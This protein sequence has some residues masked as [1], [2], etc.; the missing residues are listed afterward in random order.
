MKGKTINLLL[1]FF[2][3]LDNFCYKKISKL[4]IL[5]NNGIH[6]KHRI[7]NYHQFFV[8]NIEKGDR[9]LDVGCG[10]GAV[11]YDLA[12]KAKSV[13]GIDINKQNVE[14]AKK[15]YRHKNLNFIVGDATKFQFKRKFDVIILS[16][17]LE[18]IKNRVVFLKRIKRL[19]PKILIRVPMIDRDWLVL[20]KKEKGVEYR[21][22]KTHFTEYTIQSFGKEIK[23]ADLKIESYSIQFGEIWAIIKK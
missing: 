9:V 15:H 5:E 19:A 18:H 23:E 10:N 22:D 17:V 1:K 12:K 16:N 14:S 6:P 11:A 8:D 3:G 13:L 4:A 2:L 21:L 20:Y 7:M